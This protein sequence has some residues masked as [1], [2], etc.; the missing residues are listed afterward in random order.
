LKD[1]SVLLKNKRR[2]GWPISV[3]ALEN[4]EVKIFGFSQ[5]IRRNRKE[6]PVDILDFKPRSCDGRLC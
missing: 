2:L 6:N 5:G 3:T 1:I 4:E